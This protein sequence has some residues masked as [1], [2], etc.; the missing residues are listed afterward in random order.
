MITIAGGKINSDY[1]KNQKYSEMFENK[2]D[3]VQSTNLILSSYEN[4]LSALKLKEKEHVLRKRKEEYERIRPP[5]DKWWELKTH[6]FT[7][8]ENRNKMM[9]KATP[10]YFKKLEILHDEELY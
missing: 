6:Q 10:S 7:E 1:I 5:V 2:N 4:I 8:E 3:N 9:L